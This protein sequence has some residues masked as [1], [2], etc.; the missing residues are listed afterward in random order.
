MKTNHFIATEQDMLDLG[1]ELAKAARAG[2]IIYLEG[3]LGAG[4][5]TL[6]RGF[7]RALG[8]QGTVKSPTYTFIEP[9]ELASLSAYHVDLYRLEKPS[10]FCH[11]GLSDYLTN[12]T[13]CLIEW[14]EKA[15]EYLPTATVRCQIDVLPKGRQVK[16][17]SK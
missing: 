10:E 14:P 12:D 16:V 15:Q 6:A 7:L 4:K 5:T 1:A 3:E 13:I 8:H 17:L 9:Y 2:D 11:I